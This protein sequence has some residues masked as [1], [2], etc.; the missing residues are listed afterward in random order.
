MT[1]TVVRTARPPSIPSKAARETM[2]PTGTYVVASG[3]SR[4]RYRANGVIENAARIHAGA[5]TE[6]ANTSADNGSATTASTA[7]EIAAAIAPPSR[8]QPRVAIMIGNGA[9][10][11]SVIARRLDWALT[12]NKSA[13]AH[14]APMATT[15]RCNMT[16]A[17]PRWLAVR[18]GIRRPPPAP[19]AAERGGFEIQARRRPMAAS[20]SRKARGPETGRA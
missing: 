11:A 18:R 17:V 10:Y 19:A 12:A 15:R 8:P 13:A 20:G 9:R 3:F 6:P 4:R 16:S 1:I 7:I 5:A 14:P 2:A